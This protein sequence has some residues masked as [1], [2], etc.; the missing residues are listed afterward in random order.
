VFERKKRKKIDHCLGSYV[1]IFFLTTIGIIRMPVRMVVRKQKTTNFQ[2]LIFFF[3]T[4]IRTGILMMP[5]V[6]KKKMPT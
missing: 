1:G 6:V 4:T 2:G 5:M 3:L